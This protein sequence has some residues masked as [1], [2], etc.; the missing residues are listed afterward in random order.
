MLYAGLQ[1]KVSEHGTYHLRDN[2]VKVQ[3]TWT[4]T[5][6]SCDENRFGS[7]K[8]KKN[9]RA[10]NLTEKRPKPGHNKYG[11]PWNLCCSLSSS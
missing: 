6:V 1:T 8:E 7:R 9:E 3:L 2:I 4:V 5:A 10:L 11:V